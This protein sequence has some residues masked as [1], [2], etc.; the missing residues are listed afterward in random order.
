M[1]LIP[2]LCKHGNLTYLFC[3]MGRTYAIAIERTEQGTVALC[4]W[5]GK[6]VKYC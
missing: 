4:V 1:S 5:Y 3:K 2:S 6:I